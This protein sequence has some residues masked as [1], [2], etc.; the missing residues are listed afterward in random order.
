METWKTINGYEGKYEISS[1]GRVKSLAWGKKKILKPGM[2]NLYL[3]VGLYKNGKLTST[4]IHTLVWDHFGDELRNG[5]KLTIDHVDEN[6][7][8]NNIR[9]LQLLPIRENVSKGYKKIETTSKYTGVCWQPK[10]NKW[11]A[12]IFIK[13]KIKNLGRFIDEYDAHLAYQKALK[14]VVS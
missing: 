8:N 2:S 3:F 12:T 13:G 10:R 14:T 5:T 9:N 6:K 1:E 4:R 11:I 7:L